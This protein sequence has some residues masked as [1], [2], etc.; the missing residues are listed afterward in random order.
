[1]TDDRDETVRDNAIRRRFE[2]DGND[3][4]QT[5]NLVCPG[6]QPAPAWAIELGRTIK[7]ILNHMETLMEDTAQLLAAVTAETTIVGGLAQIV[8][9]AVASIAELR[10]LVLQTSGL[11]EAQKAEIGSS[12]A[13][14]QENTAAITAATDKLAA[15]LVENLP[16]AAARPR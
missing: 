9:N 13:K 8:D 15:G 4:T 2:R 3:I 16:P 10:V 14:V 5:V 6:N 12:F 11:S 7:S 1:M